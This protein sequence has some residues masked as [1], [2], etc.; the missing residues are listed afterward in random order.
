M[1][2]DKE[3]PA[4]YSMSTAWYCTDEERNVAIIDIEDEGPVPV[5][6]YR[7]NCFEEVFWENFF[8]QR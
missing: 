1:K 5:G 6:E 4:T 7:Q 2:T 3:Y 8:S